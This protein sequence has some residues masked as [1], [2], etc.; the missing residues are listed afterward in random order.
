M[1]IWQVSRVIDGDTLDVGSQ[2]EFNGQ[3]GT[4]VRLAN[5]NAPEIDKP[6]GLTAKQRL[7]RLVLGKQVQLQNAV[8]ISYGRLVC[9]VLLNGY[10]IRQ[11]L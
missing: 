3:T 11:Q 9:D 6:G 2:W 7:E 8:N 10:N 1:A 5:V 4:R